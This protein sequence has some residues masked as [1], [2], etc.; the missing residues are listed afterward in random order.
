M[1]MAINMWPLQWRKASNVESGLQPGG[2][3]IEAN[4]KRRSTSKAKNEKKKAK[5]KCWRRVKRKTL[6]RE[7]EAN[8]ING[9]V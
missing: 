4:E 9:G 8:E 1:K 2:V 3:I 6:W 5:Q 7:K